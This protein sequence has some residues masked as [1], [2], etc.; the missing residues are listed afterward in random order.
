M[1]VC[2]C[3]VELMVVVVAV[4]GVMGVPGGGTVLRRPTLRSTLI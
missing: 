1:C 4:R 3:V 2:V